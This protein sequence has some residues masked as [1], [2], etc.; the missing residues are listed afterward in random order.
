MLT[1]GILAIFT[2]L[3][4]PQLRLSYSEIG[5][6]SLLL[7]LIFSVA[8]S[9]APQESVRRATD[10]LFYMMYFFAIVV[11]FNRKD[12]LNIF[13][14]VL[15]IPA[16]TVIAYSILNL[17]YSSPGWRLAGL[18]SRNG[19]ARDMVAM[20]PILAFSIYDQ[21]RIQAGVRL[22][23][24][25]LMI[26]FIPLSGSRSGLVALTFTLVLVILVWGNRVKGLSL[27]SLTAVSV[28]S[29][30]AMAAGII[31]SSTVGIL[32]ERILRIPVING[33]ISPEVLGEG[34]YQV[35]LAELGTIQSY[36]LTGIG[37]GAFFQYSAER[38]GIGNYRAHS[39]V[40][41]VWMGA[42]L[43]GV[44]LLLSTGGM[45]LRNYI[46]RIILDR[47]DETLCLS[48]CLIGL[49]ATTLT[50]MFN[51]VIIQPLFYIL[52]GVG[53]SAVLMSGERNH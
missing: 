43:P 2:L 3:Y 52:V 46:R 48:G 1:C 19:V 6:L 24:V 29:L 15:V 53:S 5:I 21:N 25:G 13:V 16:T 22:I 12:S 35:R 7:L 11:Y 17:I 39:L 50:G 37:Y 51:I 23:L 40:T 10:L 30:A 26:L 4:R 41:R 45:V 42:G 20:L 32:P 27:T 28:V 44:L 33:E 8:W 18:I 38:F 34:R 14:N 36:P 31:I 9:I 49:L 47:S